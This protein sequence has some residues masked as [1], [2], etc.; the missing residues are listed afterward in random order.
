M[1]KGFPFSLGCWQYVYRNGLIVLKIILQTCFNILGRNLPWL[2]LT[3]WS[4]ILLE[5]LT[6]KLCSYS[7]NSP[8]LWNPKV[9]HRT[10]KWPPSVP[11]LSQLHP[12]PTNPSNFLKINA[13]V[14]PGHVYLFKNVLLLFV[15]HC[16]VQLLVCC[17]LFYSNIVVPLGWH[18]HWS[19]MWL[20]GWMNLFY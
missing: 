17:V 18:V 1:V 10:H 20:E 19:R 6:S 4:R 11:I 9:P 3:P 12:V 15:F 16:V 13:Q 8:H 7:R 14:S 2:H 5:K